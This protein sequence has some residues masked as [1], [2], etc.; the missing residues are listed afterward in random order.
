MSG[1][2]DD[3]LSGGNYSR[4]DTDRYC[5]DRYKRQN[6]THFPLR[7]FHS[8]YEQLSREVPGDST[9]KAGDHG[10][11]VL[12][13]GSGP[14]LAY[15]ISAA[16]LAS[17]VVFSDYLEKSRRSLRQ[18]L[19]NEE[20]AY[21]WRS[22]F[23][24]VVRG[25]E[26]GGEEDVRAREKRLRSLCRSVVTCDVTQDPPIQKG[27]EGPYDVLSTSL[28]LESC[29]TSREE[30]Q[31]VLKKLAG[32]V[33]EEGRVA[34]YSA[35]RKYASVG[36]YT[37]GNDRF[38]NLAISADFIRSALESA[39]FSDIAI[40]HNPSPPPAAVDDG[41]LGYMFVTGIKRKT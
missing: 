5:N 18:W 12:D 35:E 25:L 16:K 39:G 40:T 6:F 17:E 7:Q 22:H 14:V 24:Y 21:D 34:I 15:A 28:C 11:R 29:C 41:F 38:I 3:V 19:S 2:V 8:F 32:L 30:Y 13:Y 1:A 31:S 36:F 33:K 37:V 27:A 23:D 26:G 10:F 20:G 4:F 9:N